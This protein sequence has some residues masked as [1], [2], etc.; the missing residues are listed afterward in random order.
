M[1][2][3]TVRL[4]VDGFEMVGKLYYKK[5][6]Q[7]LTDLLNDETERFLALTD[8]KIFDPHKNEVSQDSFL[9]INKNKVVMAKPG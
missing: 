8:V 7:R 6:G 9:C 2:T 3:D 1:K 5:S 4:Y